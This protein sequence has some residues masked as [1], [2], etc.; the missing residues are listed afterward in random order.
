MVRDVLNILYVDD[1]AD[2]RT[3]VE[4][5]LGLD[6]D[7]IVKVA[8]SGMEAMEV[9]GRDG[10]LPDLMLIDVMMPGMTGMELL[11]TLRQRPD[12]A[13]IPAL[14]CTASARSTEV[15]RYIDAGAIGVV[16]KPFDP[17]RLAGLV[18][19]HYEGVKG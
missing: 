14:F 4:L 17:L 2:I 19:R 13:A 10:W 9:L 5:S 16:S 8:D 18:R 6:P 7:L 3:I 15:Q 12:T 1:E 11:A